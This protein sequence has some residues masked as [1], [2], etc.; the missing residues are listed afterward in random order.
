GEQFVAA[1][2]RK[3]E[4]SSGASRSALE[5]KIAILQ[6]MIAFA[7]TVPD[8]WSAHDRLARTSPGLGIH[9]LNLDIDIGPLLQTQK[10]VNSVIFARQR[11][12]RAL[13]AAELEMLNLTGDG[14]GLDMV[15]MPAAMR[16]L[17]PTSN[18]FQQTGYERNPVAIEHNTVAKLLARTDAIMDAESALPGAKDLGAAFPAGGAGN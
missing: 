11:L 8:E 7:R 13:S 2:R 14:N 3:A 15:A 12:R 16:E 9:A 4:T 1:L 5:Q 17:V 10:L 6:R 18:F